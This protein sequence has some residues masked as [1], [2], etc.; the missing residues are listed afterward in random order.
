MENIILHIWIMKKV[1]L[2]G[3][4]GRIGSRLGESLLKDGY[5]VIGLD[6]APGR[7]VHE[8]YSHVQTNFKDGVDLNECLSGIDYVLH[9]GAMMS[10]HPKDNVQMFEAGTWL[11]DMLKADYDAR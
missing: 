5:E 2:T 8:H 9:I 7:V 4:S 10:W 1:L 3:A 6:L 11:T